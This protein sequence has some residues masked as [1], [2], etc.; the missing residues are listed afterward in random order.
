MENGE[1]LHRWTL[2]VLLCLLPA[3]V[4]SDIIISQVYEGNSS[5]RYVEVANTGTASVDLGA[6][7]LAIWK[8]RKTSGDGST[9]GISPTLAPLSGTL[10]AGACR[11]FKNSSAN[12]PEYADAAGTSNG[13]VDF[14]GNDAI[15]LVNTGGW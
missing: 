10:D 13:A 11:V 3:T 4:W 12:N 15:A 1:R 8:K 6:Y 5:D 14:D 7:Q 9:D 2:W